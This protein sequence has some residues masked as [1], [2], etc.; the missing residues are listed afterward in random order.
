[1]PKSRPIWENPWTPAD[2]D[3]LWTPAATDDFKT[4]IGPFPGA[5]WIVM[6]DAQP[7]LQPSS[8]T[9]KAPKDPMESHQ[10]IL[11]EKKVLDMLKSAFQAG[12]E[13]PLELIEQEIR[14]IFDKAL[15]EL[16][17]VGIDK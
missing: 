1:M 8:K 17:T 3:D 4:V 11:P 13:S 9:P 7:V 16:P 10:Y 5:P 12:Y 15:S 14:Q 6:G 2:E